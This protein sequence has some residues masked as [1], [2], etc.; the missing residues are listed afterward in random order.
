MDVVGDTCQALRAYIQRAALPENDKGP[1]YLLAYGVLHSLY[2]QQDAVF[3]WCK[4][5]DV[6]PVS[7]FSGPGRWARVEA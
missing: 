3:W 6:K 5:L 7:N 1:A 2:L 4:C